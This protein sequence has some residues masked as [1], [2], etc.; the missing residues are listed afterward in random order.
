MF[1]GSYFNS[2]E[3]HRKSSLNRYVSLSPRLKYIMKRR[4]LIHFQEW[5]N[6]IKKTIQL[7]RTPTNPL[8]EQ[9]LEKNDDFLPCVLFVVMLLRIVSLAQLSVNRV[10]S[11]FDEMHPINRFVRIDSSIFLIIENILPETI[12]MFMG[13]SL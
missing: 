8:I 1:F 4:L 9:R 3:L 12:G 7:H 11:S 6:P 5:P 10:K 13:Q 2:L